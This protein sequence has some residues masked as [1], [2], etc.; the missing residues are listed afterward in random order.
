MATSLA[1]RSLHI[2][3]Q[4]EQSSWDPSKSR[5]LVREW[6]SLLAPTD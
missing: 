5:E 3:F 4:N 1:Q 2:L 6:A